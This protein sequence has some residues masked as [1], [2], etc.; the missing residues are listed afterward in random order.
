MPFGILTA[1]ERSGEFS[2]DLLR[3]GGMG[4]LLEALAKVKGDGKK[5]NRYPE[6]IVFPGY[7]FMWLCTKYAPRNIPLAKFTFKSY[8]NLIILI[9]LPTS[10][11][12]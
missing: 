11:I 9:I 7:L 1:A 5:Y 10:V 2:P 3:F 6:G 8:Q 4:A 12:K